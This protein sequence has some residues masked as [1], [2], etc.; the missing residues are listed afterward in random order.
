MIIQVILQAW[1][2]NRQWD[3]EVPAKEQGHEMNVIKEIYDSIQLRR[4][5]ARKLL[6]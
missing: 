1:E 6:A 2:I 3:F 4:A 5:M